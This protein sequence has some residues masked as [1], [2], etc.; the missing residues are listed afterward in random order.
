MLDR[1]EKASNLAEPQTMRLRGY[2]ICTASIAAYMGQGMTRDER[3]QEL[4]I[5]KKE[6][7]HRLIALY[8][9][10]TETPDLG[11]LPAN[12][13][14]TGMIDAILKNE[15][16]SGAFRANPPRAAGCA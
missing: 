8:R 5:L 9:A 16:A 1:R 14:F 3:Q 13:G 12:M 11:Q 4:L 2:F 7:P 15:A 10:A 6:N